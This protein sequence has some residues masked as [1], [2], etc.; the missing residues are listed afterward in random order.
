MFCCTFVEGFEMNRML[1]GVVGSFI[2]RLRRSLK[3]DLSFALD[4]DCRVG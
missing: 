2:E 4:L 1:F 3:C